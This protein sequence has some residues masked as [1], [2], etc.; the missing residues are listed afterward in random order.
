MVVILLVLLVVVVVV[1]LV[2]RWQTKMV[3]DKRLARA[4]E[5]VQTYLEDFEALLSLVS[6]TTRLVRE[7]E[8]ISHGFNRYVRMLSVQEEMTK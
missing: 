4:V 7:T 8:I 5:G 6:Q 1:A 3:V 2:T